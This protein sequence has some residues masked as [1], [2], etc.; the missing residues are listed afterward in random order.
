MSEQN[1]DSVKGL[2]EFGKQ[3]QACGAGAEPWEEE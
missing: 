3:Q 2:G 1:H